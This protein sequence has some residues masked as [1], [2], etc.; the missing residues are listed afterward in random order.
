MP[1]LEDEIKQYRF[2]S[3]EQR[4]LINLVY[5]YNQ[6]NNRLSALLSEFGLTPQQFNILRILRGQ[7]PEPCTNN[8]IKDRMLDKNSDVTR[9][10]DRMIKAGLVTRT[11]C[12]KN[13][14]RVD[15]VITEKGLSQLS[16]IDE[17]DQVADAL[18]AHMTNEELNTLN[19]LLD[20]VRA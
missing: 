4:A 14:R 2:R 19:G 9:I 5:T 17:R 18:F 6:V 20:K 16:A 13:R 11:S 1:R 7:H 10:I 15:I 3:E 8:L 12:S